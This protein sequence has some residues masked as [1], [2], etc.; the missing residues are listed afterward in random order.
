[1]GTLRR[2]SL[3]SVGHSA[4]IALNKRQIVSPYLSSCTW[5]Y[6]HV[7]VYPRSMYPQSCGCVSMC[8]VAVYPCAEFGCALGIN[9]HSFLMHY[10]PVRRMWIYAT[11]QCA[12]F[13]LCTMG[14]L[15]KFFDLSEEPHKS[16]SKACR[17]LKRMVRQNIVN[18]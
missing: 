3:F 1:M 14:Q 17:I 6:P 7:V 13:F 10:G 4:G 2:I 15:Y 18:V 16:H 9:A 8:M 11:G 12:E 5:P